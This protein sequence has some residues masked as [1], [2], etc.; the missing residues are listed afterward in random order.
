MAFIV[1]H[2]IFVRNLLLSRLYL[3]KLLA[4]IIRLAPTRL[5]SRVFLTSHSMM[6]VFFVDN[7]M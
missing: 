1:C 6:S 7:L 3:L 5:R 4:Y 2:S